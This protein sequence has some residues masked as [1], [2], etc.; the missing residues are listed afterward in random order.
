MSRTKH[1]FVAFYPSDWLGGTARMTRIVRSVYFDIC[2]YNWEKAEAVPEAELFLMLADLEGAGEN[3]VKQLAK[4]GKVTINDDGS[5][6]NDK[7]LDEGVKAFNLWKAKSDGGKAKKKKGEKPAPASNT[8]PKSDGD[9]HEESSHRT[10]NLELRD[11][12]NEESGNPPS[13]EVFSPGENDPIP[14]PDSPIIDEGGT[15]KN[16]AIVTAWNDM[17][18]K[19]GLTQVAKMTGER[20]KRLKV[21]I[22]E[23]GVAAIVTGINTIPDSPFLMGKNDRG[24][25]ANFDWLVQP[26]SCSKLIEGGYHNQGEGVSS[27]WRN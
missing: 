11:S 2:L 21:R 25:K 24:W 17:A 3:I 5:I 14:E 12:S 15:A 8:L 27:A 23:H 22:S 9:N 13:G 16:E 1:S 26:A 6:F 7:A 18:R 20:P 10:K 19:H 4:T